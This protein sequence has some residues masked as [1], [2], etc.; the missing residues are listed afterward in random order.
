MAPY[1]YVLSFNADALGYLLEVAHIAR[2]IIGILLS[3]GAE[4]VNNHFA[5]DSLL[6]ISAT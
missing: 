4:M 1:L 3:D 5:D 6:F 2:Q